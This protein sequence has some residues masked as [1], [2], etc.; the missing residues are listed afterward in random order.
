MSRWRWL[1][2]VPASLLLHGAGLLLIL[3]FF[4]RGALSPT[5]VVDL[6]EVVTLNGG[7][8][9][10]GSSSGQRA[11]DSPRTGFRASA[12]PA[13][14]RVLP[15]ARAL[16]GAHLFSGSPRASFPPVEARDA[17]SAPGSPLTADVLSASSPEPLPEAPPA[18]L[19]S[20][21]ESAIKSN[22]TRPGNGGE[23]RSLLVESH[24]SGEGGGNMPPATHAS[25]GGP[26][27]F[28][29]L[30]SGVVALASPGSGQDGLGSEYGTYLARL[31]QIVQE[32]LQY[33][34]AARRRGLTG[35]MHM[36]IV[37]LASGA[38]SRVSVLQS[39]SHRILDEAAVEAVRSLP[40]LP[41]PPGLSVRPIR[42][43]LPV[44]FELR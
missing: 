19:D 30:G 14:T 24:G 26:R 35:T 42:V 23:T 1:V 8:D 41:F 38:I 16:A 31:R 17:A 27:G 3:L 33:P 36:E 21:S 25:D 6:G 40:P 2:S 43:R 13:G 18:K 9:S 5:I 12:N 32:A 10:A 39:S 20:G 4:S 34:P 22:E 29:G 15:S 11:S 7:T 44:V 37:I 28:G